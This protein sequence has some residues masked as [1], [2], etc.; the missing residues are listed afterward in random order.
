VEA[1]KTASA[2]T[3]GMIV[4]RFRAKGCACGKT[5]EVAMKVVNMPSTD[6]VILRERFKRAA[7][8]R[9]YRVLSHY[10]NGVPVCA[11]CGE[12]LIGF[13]TLD[14]I[15]GDG[16]QHRK[17][18]GIHGGDIRSMATLKKRTT[19]PVIAYFA[20]T[21]TVLWASWGIA[22]TRHQ[23]ALQKHWTG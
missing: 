6:P 5:S 15:N 23:N 21:A 10:S 16:A 1:T 18:L 14:H 3:V 11:C 12:S 20:L 4:H 9:K 2:G 17:A 19:L 22:H 8:R 7:F 13:L